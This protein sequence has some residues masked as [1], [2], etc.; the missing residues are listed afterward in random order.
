MRRARKKTTTD[1]SDRNRAVFHQRRAVSAWGQGW[2]APT[3][4]GDGSGSLSAKAA[5][6]SA[7]GTYA[8]SVQAISFFAFSFESMRGGLT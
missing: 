8:P 2:Q 6:I 3:P 4:S 5:A 1:A 7:G